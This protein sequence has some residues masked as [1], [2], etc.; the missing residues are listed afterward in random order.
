[1]IDDHHAAALRLGAGV[2]VAWPRGASW[3]LELAD[4]D[5]GPAI[6]TIRS[7]GGIGAALAVSVVCI[8]TVR[9]TDGVLTITVGAA[10]NFRATFQAEHGQPLRVDRITSVVPFTL[11]LLIRAGLN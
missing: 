10:G 11:A 9:G 8:G 2:H 7:A 4:N 6:E 1:M 3:S 5:P